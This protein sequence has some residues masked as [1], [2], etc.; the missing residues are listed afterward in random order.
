VMNTWMSNHIDIIVEPKFITSGGPFHEAEAVF[1]Y[2]QTVVEVN[3][4]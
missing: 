3:I 4:A 1:S 2:I